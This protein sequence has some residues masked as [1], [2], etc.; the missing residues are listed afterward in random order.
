MFLPLPELRHNFLNN[1]VK[2]A[3]ILLGS[4]EKETYT[5]AT[6]YDFSEDRFRLLKTKAYCFN[7]RCF[8]VTSN[9]TKLS[10]LQEAKKLKVDDLMSSHGNKSFINNNFFKEN[11]DSMNRSLKN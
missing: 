11:K 4:F 6:L 5:P 3:D 8:R 10:Q 7:E 1:S 2:T 9:G